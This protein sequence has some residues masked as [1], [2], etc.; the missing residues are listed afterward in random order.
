MKRK[1]MT[2]SISFIIAILE[3]TLEEVL[4]KILNKNSLWIECSS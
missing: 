2:A 4:E 3:N 1:D